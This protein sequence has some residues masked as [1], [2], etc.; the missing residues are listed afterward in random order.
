MKLM[1]IM[2]HP[3]DAEIWCGGTLI[4]HAGKGDTVRVCTVTYP[5]HSTRGAEARKAAESIG[6][7]VEFLGLSDTAV[8]DTEESVD[9]VAAAIGSFNPDFI[10]T[11]WYEDMHPDHEGTFL[12]VRR[13]VYRFYLRDAMQI[14]PQLFCC[15]TYNSQGLRGPFKPDWLVDVGGVW[16]K[17]A[18]AINLYSSQP[19][20]FFLQMID[21]QC[22]AHG[23]TM[24][25][26]RAEGFVSYPAFPTRQEPLGGAKGLAARKM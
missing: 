23:K 12:L 9:L 5:N 2:A 13:A 7:E 25:I 19:V 4:L 22:S 11:H 24:G 26:E 1:A 8:R 14:P 21:R 20:A 3:D 10:L 6:Y 18:A 16:E 17:K 15:D